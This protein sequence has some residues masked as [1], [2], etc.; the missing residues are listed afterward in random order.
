VTRSPSRGWLCQSA[1]DHLVSL[2]SA[3]QATG[4]LTLALAGLT[5]AESASLSWTHSVFKT[6]FSIPAVE[7]REPG[8]FFQL[9]RSPYART[10]KRR[11][12]YP[13]A[14]NWPNLSYAS[15]LE[16]IGVIRAWN[17][18]GYASNAAAKDSAAYEGEVYAQNPQELLVSDAA[19]TPNQVGFNVSGSGGVVL[20]NQNFDPGWH[21]IDGRG[22]VGNVGGLLGVR[23]PSGEQWLRLASR[24]P[25]FVVGASLS[26]LSVLACGACLCWPRSSTH[27]NQQPGPDSQ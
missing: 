12:L 17:N 8:E 1:S 20:I 4:L 10:W 22:E 26:A 24:P 23:I 21:L 9:D 13:V 7:V 25:S 19:L 11:A 18:M 16:N 5:P 6:A 2:L 27:A 14:P 3:T 15:M